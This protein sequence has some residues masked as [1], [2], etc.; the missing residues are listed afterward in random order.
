[1]NKF[2]NKHLDRIDK[3]IIINSFSTDI[4]IAK[5]YAFNKRLG[6][7]VNLFY[8]CLKIYNKFNPK[9]KKIKKYFSNMYHHLPI[10]LAIKNKDNHLNTFEIEIKEKIN[11]NQLFIVKLNLPNYN[12]FNDNN[13][14]PLLSIEGQKYLKQIYNINSLRLNL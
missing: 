4:N 6:E 8:K 14:V 2:I 1:M 11:I 13:V 9:Y 7:G 5:H 10:I 12:L 3:N